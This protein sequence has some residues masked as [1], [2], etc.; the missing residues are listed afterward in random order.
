MH[1]LTESII[2]NATI[3]LIIA[4]PDD[5]AMFFYPTISRAKRLHIICLSNGGYDG[6]GEQR[7][8]E[9]QRAAR[10]LGASATCVNNAALQDGPHAWDPSVVAANVGPWL[11]AGA[12]V[13][14][15]DR[16]GASGHANHVA[17]YHGVR[18]LAQTRR[19]C[20]FYALETAPHYRRYIGAF[21][22]L[23]AAV[24][25]RFDPRPCLVQ[26]P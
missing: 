15:F 17:V 24:R 13:V 18:R 5:E 1:R 6:L 14:T 26:C 4:H 11:H 9:L 3:I 23:C 7:E 20:R 21:D 19:D 25:A 12:V 8:K 10:R 2:D 22:V 16:Y